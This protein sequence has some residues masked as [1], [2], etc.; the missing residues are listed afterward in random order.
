MCTKFPIHEQCSYAIHDDGLKGM[1]LN[2][3]WRPNLSIT[4]IDG[5]P[6][7]ALAGN[8]LRSHTS[9][10]LSM[11]LPPIFD[12][13]EALKIMKQKMTTDVPYDA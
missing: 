8:V 12:P 1:Y 7:I 9:V 2:N 13:N 5:I 10:R 11:R 3:V 6:S 4:G